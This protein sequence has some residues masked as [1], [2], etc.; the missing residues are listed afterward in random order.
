MRF[1][2]KKKLFCL[3]LKLNYEKAYGRV[4]WEF[5]DE[6]LKFGGFGV[7]WR[8]RIRSL[9]CNTYLCVRLNDINSKYFMAGKRA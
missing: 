9:L 2:P 4:D 3:V 5:L 8:N 7:I 1:I 6:M